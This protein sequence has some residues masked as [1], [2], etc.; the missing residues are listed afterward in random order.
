MAFDEKYMRYAIELAKKGEGAV[1]PNPLVGAV[2]VKDGRI[3]GSGYH[4]RYGDLHAE[5]AAFKNLTESAEGAEMYVT[6]EPCCHF[7]KQPP[8]THAVV[9]NKISKVYVGSD[10]PNEMVAG[11]GIEYL[12]EHGIEV[13]TGVLKEECDAINRPF[14]HYITKKT[15]YVVMKYAMTMDGKIACH[16][17]DSKWVSNEESRYFVQQL[18]NRYVGIMVGINTVLCDNPSFTC[19]IEGG[20]NPI[21]IICDSSL[22]IPVD[23]NIVNTAKEVET[24]VATTLLENKKTSP[25][26]ID[27]I[28]ILEEKGIILLDV[29]EEDGHVDTKD[30]MI[31]LGERKIDSILLEGGGTLNYGM[32]SKDLVNEV[33]AFVAPKIVGGE[34]SPTPVAGAGIDMMCDAKSFKL[35]QV[36]KIGEDIMLTYVKE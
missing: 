36:D 27:K 18:R 4:A 20:R 30:L 11:K 17:K 16:T 3:I 5:R 23:S 26:L 21:R 19:R 22:R 13:V 12:R 29:A 31:K 6:L 24:I 32:I 28:K 7:G 9:E 34:K 35:I 1:N 8:C 15:P 2:I 14:F 25:E 10:D 33:V